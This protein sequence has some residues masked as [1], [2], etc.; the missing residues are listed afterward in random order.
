MTGGRYQIRSDRELPP[1]DTVLKLFYNPANELDGGIY[2]RRRSSVKSDSHKPFYDIEIPTRVMR[3]AKSL[4]VYST[5]F[6]R[7]HLDIGLSGSLSENR[8]TE[9][10]TGR[11]IAIDLP[12]ESMEKTLTRVTFRIYPLRDHPDDDDDDDIP[13]IRSVIVEG[14]NTL[15]ERRY[16]DLLETFDDPEHMEFISENWEDII[17]VSNRA[18]CH[19]RR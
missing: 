15:H 18:F 8:T 1:T 2:T 17:S 12:F 5:E 7:F 11:N 3:V 19:D 10:Q 9:F 6:S 13:S 14:Y 4:R 16:Y